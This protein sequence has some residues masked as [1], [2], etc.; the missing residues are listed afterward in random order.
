MDYFDVE[1]IEY[2]SSPNVN[3]DILKFHNLTISHIKNKETG[4]DKSYLRFSLSGIGLLEVEL[5]KQVI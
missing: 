3:I 1:P 5:L 4:E 2:G